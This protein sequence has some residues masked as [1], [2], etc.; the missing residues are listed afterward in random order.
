MA[1]HFAVLDIGS[2]AIKSQI[3]AVDHPQRYRVIEQDRQPVRLGH[4]VFKTR[5]LN[6]AVAESAVNVLLQFK[7]LSTQ[8]RVKGIKAV[9][10]SALREALD[11]KA[12]Q[13][14][15]QKLGIPLEVISEEEEARLISLGLMSGLRF[16]LPLGLFLDIGGGSVELSV[17]N[18]ANSFCLFSLPLGA[19]RLTE[20]FVGNDPPR[21]REIREIRRFV[22]DK[23]ALVA[24]RI[25]QEKFT[26]AFGS[27]GTI[28]ALAETDSR[29][30]GDSKAA[31]LMILRRSRLKALLE[32][33]TSQ[34][35]AERATFISGDPK[36]AD[37]IIAGGIVL[38]EVMSAV[39]LDYLFVSRRG[40]RD[41]LMVDLLQKYY[42]DSGAWHPEAERAESL[43]QVCQKYL[44]D[45][46]HAQHVSQ[47]A[48]NAFYQLHD[49]HQLPE[50]YA[51]VL[52]AAAM[53]HD[54]GL[55]IS[56]PK[57]HKHSYYLIKSSGLNSFSKLDL[58]LIANVARYHR[59]AHPSQKH[60]PF[61]QL[62]PANQNVV[63]KLSAILRVADAFDYK[64]EQRVKTLTCTL[65][66]SKTL[67]ILATA[68]ASL[69]DELD[70]A[71][72]KGRL[73]QEVFNVD[74]ELGKASGSR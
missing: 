71:A 63:R 11:G 31:S 64:R 20:A 60:L 61:S 40:L 33:L 59:K 42:A 4:D 50:K 17:A 9:G 43:E 74:L 68:A 3:A 21:N 36:R 46:A 2:N 8:Y 52:N 70:W 7:K 5:K 35:V 69:K 44:Y 45:S 47:L 72:K 67:T 28:T 1:D 58:D 6:P 55:F 13:R 24:R 73:I 23:L 18:T 16:H 56:H 12:F 15:V 37:I 57:H 14:R 62:S 39:G 51:S 66:K 38:D 30:A 65:K 25:E 19:V 32:K 10:T 29:A 34:T 49:L 26:M 54:I 41:G 22:Q 27:G 53:L 48:L